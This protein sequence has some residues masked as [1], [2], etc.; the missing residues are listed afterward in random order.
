MDQ[1]NNQSAK[2]TSAEFAQIRAEMGLTQQQLAEL[3]GEGITQRDISRIEIA[4]N[5]TR[6][7]AAFIKY[8]KAKGKVIMQERWTP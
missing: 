7:Q 6:W 8:I 3:M 1:G 5:P 4:R 2:M